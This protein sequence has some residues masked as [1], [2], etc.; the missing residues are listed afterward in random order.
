LVQNSVCNKGEIAMSI[1]ITA[2]HMNAPEAKAH[3][4]ERAEQLVE[5]FP[6][7]ESIH[8]ILDT[9]KHHCKAEFVV[10]AKN[11]IHKEA[12]ETDEEMI[13]AIDR[14]FA[15]TEKQMRK[16]RDKVQDHRGHASKNT[17]E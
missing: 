2:R 15:R 14:A 10:R 12:S 8:V 4:N 11:H 7:I 17:E 1:E 16:L 5:E 3:A 13:V 6:R 9:E